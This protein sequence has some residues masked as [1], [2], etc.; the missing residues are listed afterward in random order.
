MRYYSYLFHGLLALFLA[1]VSGVA[2]ASS[3][4]SLRLDMLP[5]TGAD[6]TYTV[7]YGSLLGLII[8]GLAAK[9]VLPVLLLVW[10]LLVS[11]MLIYGYVFSRYVFDGD[12]KLAIALIVGS[13]IAIP[14]PWLQM[15][16]AKQ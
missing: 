11:G 16:P 14:G 7:F 5:W 8:V 15:R 13:L 10:S 3:P 6:L 9:R 12:L 1:G 4:T 2:L